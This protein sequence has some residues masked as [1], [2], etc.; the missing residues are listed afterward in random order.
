M[1]LK[2]DR[3]S[4]IT[5]SLHDTRIKSVIFSIIQRIRLRAS[6]LK[7]VIGI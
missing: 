5:F 3:N 2:Q 4:N 6:N 7:V 1:E